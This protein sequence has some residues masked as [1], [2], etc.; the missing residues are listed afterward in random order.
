MWTA[1]T[2]KIKWNSP[3]DEKF[4]HFQHVCTYVKLLKSNDWNA[5]LI[6]FYSNE[7]DSIALSIIII[8]GMLNEF[9]QNGLNDK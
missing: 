1:I 9:F 8:V 2:S 7:R 6:D 5:F 3:N 4:N